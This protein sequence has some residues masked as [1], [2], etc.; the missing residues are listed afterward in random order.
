MHSCDRAWNSSLVVERGHRAAVGADQQ[1][2]ARQR[3]QIATD[4]VFRDAELAA[5]F[6]RVDAS[7]CAELGKDG[8]VTFRGE[9]ADFCLCDACIL[10][11][12]AG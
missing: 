8:I 5:Q 12:L 4:R 7:V 10:P 9:Q 11:I 2:V 1:A 6:G 3:R